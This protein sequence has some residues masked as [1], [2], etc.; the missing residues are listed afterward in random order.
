MTSGHELRALNV[1]NNTKLWM[2]C[3][4]L[5]HELKDLDAMKSLGLWMI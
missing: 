3:T 5:G 2:I 1:M 4:C